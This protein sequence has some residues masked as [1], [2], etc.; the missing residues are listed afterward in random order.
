MASVFK[1]IG[2]NGKESEKWYYRFLDHFNGKPKW[3]TLKGTADYNATHKIAKQAE[4]KAALKRGGVVSED[5]RQGDLPLKE[6]E[7]DLRASGCVRSHADLTVNQIRTTFDACGIK[8]LR[9]LANAA[10][11]IKTYL[12]NKQR[13]SRRKGKVKYKTAER[14]GPISARTRNAYITS[15]RQFV[16]YCK[17]PPLELAKD[18]QPVKIVQRRAATEAEFARILKSAKA[19]AFVEGLTGEQRYWLYRTA[20]NTG[21]RASELRSLTPAAFKLRDATPIIVVDGADTKN[22]AVANQPVHPEFAAEL[23][24]WLRCKA[25]DE[26]VWGG[27]W[28]KHAAEMLRADLKAAKVTYRTDR[29]VLDFHAIRATFITG[30]ARAK[31]HPKH[32]QILAR[33]SDIKLTMQTYTLLELEEVAAVLPKA[34]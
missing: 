24:E 22:G 20:V 18:K 28:N 26:P 8:S 10:T 34:M 3:R 27:E 17:L 16:K 1:R 12:A 30:L 13:D 4:T 5:E 33:H 14:L 2:R 9:D 15:I 29:G 23:A 32:A 7:A 6:F 19:G 25:D 21:F 31:V 11:R